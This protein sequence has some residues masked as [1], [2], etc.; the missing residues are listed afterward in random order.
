[1]ILALSIFGELSTR[2]VVRPQLTDAAIGNLSC[3][4]APSMWFLIAAR[5]FTGIGGGGISTGGFVIVAIS[6]TG[7]IDLVGSVVMSDIVPM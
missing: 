4:A 7:L 3:A 6:D 1:M 5:A 2:C